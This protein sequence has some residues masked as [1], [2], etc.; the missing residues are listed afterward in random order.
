MIRRLFA[1]LPLLAGLWGCG[2]ERS[3]EGPGSETS[4][5]AARILDSTG[6]PLAGVAVR[7]V[8]LE[9]SWRGA[10]ASGDSPVLATGRTDTRGLVRFSLRDSAPVALEVDDPTHAGRLRAVPGSDTVR[11]LRTAASCALRLSASVPGETILGLRLAGTGYEGAV[12]PDGSW[13]IQGVPRGTY[14]VAARTDS[15]LALV[16][17]VALRGGTLDT[18]LS[19][20]VDSVLLEDFA[21]TPSRN[22]YGTL[23]GAGWWYAVTD[24]QDGGSSTATPS[25]PRQ[26]LVPCAVGTC[27]EM[28]FTLDPA[29]ASRYALVGT[30]PDGSRAPGDALSSHADFSKVTHVRFSASGWGT[31]WFQLGVT[32]ASGG[33]TACHSTFGLGTLLA[34]T[35]IAMSSLVCDASDPDFRSVEGMTWTALS[36]GHLTLGRVRLVGAG[37]REVFEGLRKP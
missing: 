23:L 18:A 31:F 30:T 5:L 35:E 15:G 7:V 24:A 29:R 16:G 33:W 12:Q 13:L 9:T 20:D 11:E 22:R 6:T 26:A 14:S 37:P 19:A 17:R 1:C 27:L 21:D 4:G 32:R 28:G 25:D 8:S 36:D 34:E 3:T 10:F 2:S